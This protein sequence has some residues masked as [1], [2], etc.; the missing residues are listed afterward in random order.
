MHQYHKSWKSIVFSHIMRNRR[1]YQSWQVWIAEGN[2]ELQLYNS[3]QV[4]F[5][6]GWLMKTEPEAY[7]SLVADILAGEIQLEKHTVFQIYE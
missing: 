6:I 4:S 7:T 1:K 3:G 2:D 5:G